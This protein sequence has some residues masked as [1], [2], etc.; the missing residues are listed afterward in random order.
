MTPLRTLLPPLLSL[1]L[2]ATLPAQSDVAIGEWRD[3]FSYRNAVAVEMGGGQVY[4]ASANAVFRYDPATRE[5][6]RLTKVN[7]LNDVGIL[8]LAWNEPS[9]TLLVRYSNGNIDLLRGERT[10]NMGDIKRSSILGDKAI[11]SAHFEGTMA[12]LGCG[13][14]VV[15][16]DLARREVRETWFIGPGG[17]QLRVNG[18]SFRGDSIYAATDQGLYVASRHAPNLAAFTNWRKRTDLPPRMV[19]GPF[20]SVVHFAGR[21]FLNYKA[22]A[23]D[24]DTVLVAGPDGTFARQVGWY[25]RTNRSFTVDAEGRHLV[26][27]TRFHVHVYDVDLNEVLFQYGYDNDLVRANQAVRGTDGTIWVADERKGLVRATGQDLG[28]SIQPNGP[29]NQNLYRLASSGGALYVATGGVRGN[30]TNEFRKEGVHHY[31]DGVWRTT[32]LENTP[33]F[34]TGANTYGQALNDIMAVAV[35]PADPGHAFA[36]SWEDGL[37]EFRD[38][39]AVMIHNASNSALREEVGSSMGKVNVG[40]LSYDRE[41]NLWMTNALATTPIVVRTKA[42]E[43]HSFSP[44]SLLAGNNLVSDILAARNGYK[45]VIRPRGNALLVF[46]D[47]GTISNT[48]DDRYKLLDNLAGS[49]GLPSR[50]VFSLAEDMDGQIWVGTNK[51]IAVFYAPEALFGTGDSDAQ[52]ILIEQ[53]GNVQV[54]LETELVTSIAVDGANRKWLGTQT[55]GVFLVSPDGRTQVLHFTAANSPLPS[56]NIISIAI[57][58]RSGEVFFGTDRGIISYR[59]DATEGERENAC[60]TVFPNPV[61]ESWTGPVAITG[62]V[63]DSEVRITDMA[64]NLVYRTTSLGGQAIWPG[65]DMAGNRVVTGVYLVMATDRFGSYKCNTKVLVAR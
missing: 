34:V 17:Q 61:R 37:V 36:G 62:L 11:H 35:D 23:V 65:T 42:G 1:P 48:G 15:V 2:T 51:G 18:I 30:W 21:L 52:Q 27:V 24:R 16:L 29:R 3:H 26:N 50:E 41:G 19:D 63:R 38:R 45:W 60:A 49:G 31:Q 22:T 39:N 10:V 58:G 20:S 7:A 32:D 6:A 9:G 46:D 59:S 28:T 64:G 14:G 56:D 53:D 44:G 47:G 5:I 4:C 33:L 12:Y 55:S 43:W 13:F 25:G 57:D 40:G 8:G 54:L